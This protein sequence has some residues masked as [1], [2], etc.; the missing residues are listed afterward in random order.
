M[1]SG[2][3]L[4]PAAKHDV[5]QFPPRQ[6]PVFPGVVEVVARTISAFIMA[7]PF[8]ISGE[9]M[10]GIRISWLIYE[11]FARSGFTSDKSRNCRFGK[12]NASPGSSEVHWR[13]KSCAAPAPVILIPALLV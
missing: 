12:V 1:I 4:R 11:L 5:G 2:D 6:M 3:R 7:D 10:G 13:D 8:I 9:N